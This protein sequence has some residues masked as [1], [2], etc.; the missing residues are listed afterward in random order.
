MNWS[1]STLAAQRHPFIFAW[2]AFTLYGMV[3]CAAIQLLI[4]PYVFPGIHAGHGLLAGGDFPHL[5]S[6]AARM[7]A[8]ITREGWHAWQLMPDGQSA[9]GMASAIYALTY[10]EPWVLI[11]LNAS[12]H[13]LGAIF[14]M[15]LVQILTNDT[16][17][18]FGGGM[19]Y[20]S[21]PSSLHWVSQIQKDSTYSAGMLAVLLGLVT[22]IQAA[23][24]KVKSQEIGLAIGLVL[25]GLVLTGMARL[26]GLEL[27]QVVVSVIAIFAIPTLIRRWWRDS[28]STAHLV[29]TASR[30][31]SNISTTHL[32]AAVAV[33]FAVIFANKAIP[34]S[35]QIERIN[36]EFP[37]VSSVLVIHKPEVQI[38]IESQ[39]TFEN[40]VN[41]WR[42]NDFLPDIVDRTALRI[43]VARWGW[44]GP[45]YA[46]AGSMIDIDSQF[47]SAGGLVGYLP[48]ALQI[49]FLA[50]FPQHWVT[51]KSSPGNAVMR[52]AAGIEMMILYP[53]FLIGLPL[54]MW[55]WRRRLELW[56]ILAYCT[57]V[58]LA[59]T[60][61]I[62]NVGSL[63]R[64]RYGLLMPLAAVGMAAIWLSLRE[65]QTRYSQPSTT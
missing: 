22:L 52:G 53:M 26:Y 56:V 44:T 29:T 62:P 18:A 4:L 48:R 32:V 46:T 31:G 27:I 59:F 57:P 25:L 60:Y 35:W 16:A 13:A 9:A 30:W 64:L 24:N 36:P 41:K 51:Q 63:H 8:Q 49:G 3:A 43:A 1:G 34:P 23:R 65:W 55:R 2:L 14:V 15:R 33:M 5:H 37:T 45:T 40:K 7:S 50:P 28:T 20:V 11:P 38:Q 21:L 10:P 47:D 39:L 54:A 42:R 61:V 17:I 6:I 19:L 12:L 58:L